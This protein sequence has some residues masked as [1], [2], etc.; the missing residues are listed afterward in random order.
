VD[1]KAVSTKLDRVLTMRGDPATGVGA[2]AWQESLTEVDPDLVLRAV[3]VA[4]RELLV[5]DWAATRKQDSRPQQ[6]LDAAQAW[7]DTKSPE[8][9][10]A[11]KTAAK[12]CTAARS[13]TFGQDHR[14]PEAARHAAW[15]PAAKD[16]SGLFEA[17]AA[18]EHELLARIALTGE[19]HR[20]PE[21][22]RAIV[23]IL[24]RVILP[25]EPA[26]DATPQS[27]AAASADPVPYSPEGHFELGQRLTHKKFGEVTVTSVGETWIE[28]EIP[29]DK[30]KKRLAHK[31]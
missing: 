3:I 20:G 29:A 2:A 10:A 9:A 13:E 26:A 19:L 27:T 11:A 21:Q 16:T 12:G 18:T 17:L 7:V 25:P 31:P 24:K 30:S 1:P 28:V 8:A 15:A 22:R 5:P 4:V 6:A 23:A 14:V